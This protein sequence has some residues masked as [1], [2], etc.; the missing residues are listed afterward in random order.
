MCLREAQTHKNNKEFFSYFEP[1]N[2]KYG[3][4]LQIKKDQS[5][6]RIAVSNSDILT[7][8]LF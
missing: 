4:I 1:L 6:F 5:R 3:L 7:G 8:I 2:Y